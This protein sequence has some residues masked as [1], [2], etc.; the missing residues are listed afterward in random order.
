MLLK[1]WA[2][3]FK[4]ML[5]TFLSL[6]DKT[7]NCGEVTNSIGRDIVNQYYSR[8]E[9]KDSTKSRVHI[10]HFTE[11]FSILGDI[12]SH[13]VHLKNMTLAP[14]ALIPYCAFKSDLAIS[15]NNLKLPGANFPFCSLF[16]PTILEGQL[17][18]KLLLNMTSGEGK[19]NELMLLLDYNEYLSLQTVLLQT[20]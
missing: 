2:M 10:N 14:S 11:T 15:N 19:E 3:L 8:E 7:E 12:V 16:Q 6:E 1:S 13:P 4:L 18:Y 17:C 9:S 20:F 5:K